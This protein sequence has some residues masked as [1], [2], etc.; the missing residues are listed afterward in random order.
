MKDQSKLAETGIKHY[1]QRSKLSGD[2]T[3]CDHTACTV[4]WHFFHV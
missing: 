4:K 3:T 1:L 2:G